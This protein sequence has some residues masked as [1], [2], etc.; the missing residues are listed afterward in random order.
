MTRGYVTE[1]EEALHKA[2][3]EH[4][5]RSRPERGVKGLLRLVPLPMLALAGAAPA[6]GDRARR[7]GRAQRQSVHFSPEAQPALS[8][9]LGDGQGLPDP[10]S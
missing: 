8:G 9:G 1:L 5:S 3:A 6:G 10:R 7:D 2:A 4:Y